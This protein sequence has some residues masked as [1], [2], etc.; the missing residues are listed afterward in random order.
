MKIVVLDGYTLNPGDLS[1]GELEMLGDVIVYD[2]TPVE[3]VY[4]RSSGAE[5]LLTNKTIL[6]TGILKKLPELR[7]VGV[8]A[9]GYN[10]IDPAEAGNLGI[11]VT[12]IPAYSTDSV[13]QI[14]FA[15]ILEF[16]FHVQKHSDA[17]KSGKW[18][19]SADFT[20]RD[21]PLTELKSK[22]LG[23][24]GFG[25]IGK[26]VG[27]IASVFGMNILAYS[28][29]KTDQSQRQNF[30][31]VDLPELFSESDFLTIHC[32]LTPETRNL[33]DAERLKLMKSTAYIINTSRGPIVS[34]NDLANALN[35]S[36]IAGAGLDVLSIEPPSDNNPLL[37]A[38]NCIITPHIAWAT[39]EARE[40]LMKT[41]VS[42]VK[43]FLAGDP[44]NVVS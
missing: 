19:G 23:I 42:N 15:F 2:R 36:T 18:S 39:F 20:F 7:Y 12:N 10:V 38:G 17:V 16:C 34:E 11:V 44:V 3:L 31:W 28:R 21:Y 41:A 32:P 5:I 30:R 8:L 6:D 14:T 43:A 33:V 1:W 35:N 40:R 24:L 29:T 25:S 13:A 22:N 37:T 9:T 26:K 27:D 4:E